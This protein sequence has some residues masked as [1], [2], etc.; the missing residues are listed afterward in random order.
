MAVITISRLVGSGGTEIALRVCELLGY[1]Y[2]DKALMAQVAAEAGM[3]A[4]EVI[5]LSEDTYKVRGFFDRLFHARTPSV[6]PE[7]VAAAGAVVSRGGTARARPQPHLL[8]DQQ[9]IKLVQRTIMAAYELGDLII[10]GRA[11]QILLADKPGTLHVRL[12]AP[13]SWRVEHVRKEMRL[14]EG[15]AR[16]L[17]ADIDRAAA[18]YIKRF[19]DTDW[20]EPTLYHLVLNAARWSQEAMARLVVDAVGQLPA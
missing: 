19:Y 7:A 12:E 8:D 14:S 15:E 2:F 18:S 11:G 1:R 6:F 5:D 10:V 17:V 3:S 20:R 4:G 16:D 9:S 13:V